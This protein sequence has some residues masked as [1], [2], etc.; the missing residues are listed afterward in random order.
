[1]FVL[2][3]TG[4][5]CAGKTSKLKQLSKEEHISICT[6]EW[7]WETLG[8]EWTPNMLRSLF[9]EIALFYVGVNCLGWRRI[10]VLWKAVNASGWRLL[11]RLNVL[12]NVFHKFAIHSVV[13]KQNT[14]QILLLDEGITHIPYLFSTSSTQC[15]V[16]IRNY[17]PFGKP[18]V[19]IV[20]EELKTIVSRLRRRGHSLVAKNYSAEEFATANE[21]V[22]QLQ[23]LDFQSFPEEYLIK[24]QLPSKKIVRHLAKI[25]S[26]SETK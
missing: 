23:K 14:L 2:E 8:N 10:L 21:T 11:R 26:L 5:P 9:I 12:R 18:A 15:P 22:R 25:T 13:A 1:M 3:L 6:Q 20:E 16:S 24:G 19:L 7:L 4:P 17:Y